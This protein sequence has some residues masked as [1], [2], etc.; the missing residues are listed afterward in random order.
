MAQMAPLVTQAQAQ[1]APP[2]RAAKSQPSTSAQPP[3]SL[4]QGSDATD[5]ERAEPQ[6]AGGLEAVPAR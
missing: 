5:G 6:P 1:A 3:I 2:S 4:G